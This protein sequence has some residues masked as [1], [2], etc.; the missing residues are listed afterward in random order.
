M[1]IPVLMYHHVSPTAGAH[2]VS[3]ECFRSHLQWF[4]DTGVRTLSATEFQQWREGS[5]RI[6]QP[7]VLITFDDGWLDNWAYALPLL[8]EFNAKATMFVVTSWPGD[9]P[10]RSNPF[11]SAP[12][13]PHAEAMLLLD[14]STR[15]RV[16]MRWEELLAARETGL[17]ELASHSHGHGDWWKKG[18]SWHEVMEG[19]T[20]DLKTSREVLETRL[21]NPIHS[22]CWPKGQF[23]LEAVKIAESVGFAAQFSTLRGSNGATPG[24]LIRRIDAENRDTRWLASRYRLYANGVTGGMLGLAH[25]FLHRFRMQR[26]LQP[27]VPHDECRFPLLTFI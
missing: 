25:Q 22:F 26:A 8:K 9:G 5:L 17:V 4:S 14:D 7:S 19:L 10:K 24:R 1:S 15:D 27:L 20:C 3:P 16:V 11:E 13:P 6:Q 21:G 23:S 18:K 2:T 12:P